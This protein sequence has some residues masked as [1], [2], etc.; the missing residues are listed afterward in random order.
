MKKF[1]ALFALMVITLAHML[2]FIKCI[3]RETIITS[4]V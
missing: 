3:I 2:K 4:F 1:I